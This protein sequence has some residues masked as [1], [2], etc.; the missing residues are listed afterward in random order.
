MPPSDC[1]VSQ[2]REE[3]DY[4]LKQMAR[5]LKADVRPA[6]ELNLEDMQR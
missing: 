2:T 3:N 6:S 1:V 4:A 5:V